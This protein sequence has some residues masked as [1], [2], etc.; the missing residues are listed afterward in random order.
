MTKDAKRNVIQFVKQMATSGGKETSKT[1]GRQVGKEFAKNLIPFA[2]G[3]AWFD[4]T[5]MTWKGFFQ[6]TGLSVVSSG[7]HDVGKT[8]LGDWFEIL[9]TE[10]LKQ[11]PKYFG[12]NTMLFE[13]AKKGAEDELKKQSYK[14]HLKDIAFSVLKGVI[15]YKQGKEKEK[16]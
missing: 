15:R 6:A 1:M 8:V 4:G 13:V 5:K 2:V 7:G 12:F 11:K 16:I 10:T 9:I 3:E 14:F